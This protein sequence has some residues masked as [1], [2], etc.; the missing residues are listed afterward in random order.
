MKRA[1]FDGEKFDPKKGQPTI[2]QTDDIQLMN[3]IM[4]A[5]KV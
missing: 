3:A 2:P 4:S 5:Y 1:L